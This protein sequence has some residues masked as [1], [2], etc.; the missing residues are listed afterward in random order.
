MIDKLDIVKQ[1]FDEVSDLIIQPDIIADQKR[2]VQLTKEYSELKDLMAKRDQYIALTGNIKEAEE[3]I[4]GQR[5]GRTPGS[6]GDAAYQHGINLLVQG[7]KIGDCFH[8]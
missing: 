1:R 3:I 5:F 7:L 4:K 6:F 2:Y 8:L